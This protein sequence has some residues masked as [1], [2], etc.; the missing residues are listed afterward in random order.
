MKLSKTERVIQQ[1]EAEKADAQKRCA[2]DVAVLELAIKRIRAAQA[3]AP[4]RAQKTKA[5]DDPRLGKGSTS[6]TG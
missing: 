2:S 5:H 3:S 4:K 6:P 1:L